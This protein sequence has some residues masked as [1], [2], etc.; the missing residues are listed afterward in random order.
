MNKQVYSDC[1]VIIR[2]YL[3][4]AETI[5]NQSQRTINGY[6]IDLRT[7]FRFMKLSK[8][9]VSHDVKF[10]DITINDITLEFIKTITTMDIYEYMHYSMNTLKNNAFSSLFLYL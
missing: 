6:F 2:E 10:K 4:Y 3:F 1:P 9:L 7:F 5:K 8:S